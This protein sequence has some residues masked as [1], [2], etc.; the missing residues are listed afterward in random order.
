MVDVSAVN[1]NEGDEAVI[2]ENV[3]QIN[4]VAKALG[5]IPYEALT[6]VSGRVKRIYVQE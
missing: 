1:C 3:E 5:S 2:F 4:R 6:N